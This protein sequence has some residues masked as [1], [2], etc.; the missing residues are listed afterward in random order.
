MF[1]RY[2]AEIFPP[3]SSTLSAV[4]F[5]FLLPLLIS[6]CKFIFWTRLLLLFHLSTMHSL[7]FI[8][9]VSL[10]SIPLAAQSFTSEISLNT[11]LTPDC[12]LFLVLLFPVTPSPS[13][14]ESAFNHCHAISHCPSS[15]FPLSTP[16]GLTF[17]SQPYFCYYHKG[18]RTMKY[19][20]HNLCT[21]YISFPSI[22][23]ST[24]I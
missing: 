22:I 10:Y 11:S 2:F 20:T 3:H 17:P 7:A 1:S 18:V 19:S 15:Q 5:L 8:F 13:F 16:F 9:L 12:V 23:I 4:S 6:L 14:Y 21:Q 24:A